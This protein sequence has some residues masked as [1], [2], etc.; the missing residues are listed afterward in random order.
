[1]P[2][3]HPSANARQRI[4][5]SV[6]WTE[7]QRTSYAGPSRTAKPRPGI[8]AQI[9]G[10]TDGAH[11]WKKVAPDPANP[12]EVVDVSPAVTGT[13]NAYDANGQTVANDT[14]V[15]LTLHGRDTSGNPLYRFA[16]GGALPE[17]GLEYMVLQ[18]QEVDENLVPVWDWV[19]AHA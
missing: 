6:H 19:R 13:E 7:S 18:L 12:G 8:L 5:R 9:T 10:N 2:G 3:K 11:S 16:A 15:T 14:I 1:M 4:R 17:P